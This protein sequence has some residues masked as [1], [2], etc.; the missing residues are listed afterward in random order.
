MAENSAALFAKYGDREPG[1]FLD[2]PPWKDALVDWWRFMKRAY[3]VAHGIAIVR[4]TNE[5][6]K[7]SR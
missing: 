7:G 2:G 6:L 4:E 3:V 5:L 1:N